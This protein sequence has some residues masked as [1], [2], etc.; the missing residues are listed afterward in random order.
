MYGHIRSYMAIQL[1]CSAL[2]CSC[3]A[4]A[5]LC[6]CSALLCPRNFVYAGGHAYT[7]SEGLCGESYSNP[8]NFLYVGGQSC[9][10]VNESTWG[11][12]FPH[13]QP[14]KLLHLRGGRSG[15]EQRDMDG[16][17][18]YVGGNHMT[19]IS[20]TFHNP[21]VGGSIFYVGGIMSIL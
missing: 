14:R 20:T 5:L 13:V 21:Y 10:H 7:R 8:R 19:F 16:S 1:I 12:D 17:N 6:S 2:L 4:V 3:S 11:F 18:F 15:T 9:Y